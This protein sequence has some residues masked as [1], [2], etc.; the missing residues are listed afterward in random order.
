A[1]SKRLIHFEPAVPMSAEEAARTPFG[2]T[3][4]PK[5]RWFV[6][7]V[8]LGVGLVAGFAVA[9]A[10]VWQLYGDRTKS[11]TASAGAASSVGRADV[12]AAPALPVLER[13]VDEK[14][15]VG[16]DDGPVT[17]SRTS[18]GSVAAAP[19]VETP[20]PGLQVQSRPTGATVYLDGQLVSTTPFQLTD[21]APGTYIIRIVQPGY[22]E[23]SASVHVE[24]GARTRVSASLELE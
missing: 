1:E 9:V 19:T 10:M 2:A 16:A 21:I 20:T 15:F 5:G 24:R 11:S 13:P 14:G 22:S 6:G 23:W 12:Q 4:A 18:P 7:S 3:S 17:Q 8:M